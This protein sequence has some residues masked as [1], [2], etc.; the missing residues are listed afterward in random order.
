ML[1]SLT[2]PQIDSQVWPDSHVEIRDG[3]SQMTADPRT[4]VAKRRQMAFWIEE[5]KTLVGSVTSVGL[6]CLA[7]SLGRTHMYL[8]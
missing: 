1:L 2:E 8:Y 3:S 7:L 6:K 4:C 5:K